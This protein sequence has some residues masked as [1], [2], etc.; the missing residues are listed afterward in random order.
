MQKAIGKPKPSTQLQRLMS[1]Q[2]L[3]SYDIFELHGE[4][5]YSAL[6]VLDFQYPV[7]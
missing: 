7:K 6:G 3:V 2:R 4:V 1:V 5:M